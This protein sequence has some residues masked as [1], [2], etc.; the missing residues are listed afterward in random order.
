LV[1]GDGLK[2]SEVIISLDDLVILSLDVREAVLQIGGNGHQVGIVEFLDAQKIA[3]PE[4]PLQQ[5][6]DNEH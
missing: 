5:A 2:G 3:L 4:P 6:L 1:R